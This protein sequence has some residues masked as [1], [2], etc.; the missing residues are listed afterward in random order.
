MIFN[1]KNVHLYDFLKVK[2]LFFPQ[3]AHWNTFWILD[4]V[5]YDS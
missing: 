4:M 3:M 5:A 1:N 2:Y